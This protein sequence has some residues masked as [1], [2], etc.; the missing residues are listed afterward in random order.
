MAKPC[1]QWRL[2]PAYFQKHFKELCSIAKVHIQK[3]HD[4]GLNLFIAFYVISNSSVVRK[5]V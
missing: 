2:W 1:C 4:R 5:G 3:I